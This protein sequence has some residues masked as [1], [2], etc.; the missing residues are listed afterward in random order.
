MIKDIYLLVGGEASRLRPL[1]EGIPKALLTI[2]GR[3]LI[4]LILENL[5][6]SNLENI[7]LICSIKHE[8]FW[9]EYKKNSKFNV[10]LHFEHEKLDTGGYVMKNIEHFD[11]KFLCMNGDLLIE[12][13]FNS[14]VEVANN[15]ENSTIC[16]IQVDDPSRYGV[17]ELDGTKIMNFIEKPEDMKY[18]NNI[19]LG[20]YCLHKKDIR[21]IKINLEVPCSF[22]K[23]VFP[24]LAKNNLLDCFSVNGNMLDVGTRQSYI[25]AH[26]ENQTNW[27]SESANIGKDTVIENSVILGSSSIGNNV[28]VNNSIIC[29]EAIIE[30][31]AVINDEIFKS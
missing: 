9:L 30:D 21:K 15:S 28:Q 16:S 18:G 17:L 5:E 12:M 29:S 27:I 6:E 14:F 31:E 25:Y 8:K 10:N 20:V 7:N 24:E 4:D 19:S 11:D 22:E 1:S 23:N 3:L 26:T 13:N 2:K